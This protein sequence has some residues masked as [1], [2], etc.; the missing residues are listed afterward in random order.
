MHTGIQRGQTFTEALD[1]FNVSN[2]T[3]QR[4][5]VLED[6]SLGPRI[7]RASGTVQYWEQLGGQ[8]TASEQAHLE[9]TPVPQ[10]RVYATEEERVMNEGTNQ[11]LPQEQVRSLANHDMNRLQD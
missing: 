11:R 2:G 6:G 5:D 1:A 8:F 4:V 3:A 9:H 10:R 7:S